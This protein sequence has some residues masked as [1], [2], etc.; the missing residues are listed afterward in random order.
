MV[1]WI[2]LDWIGYLRPDQFLDQLTMI[3]KWFPYV[4]NL[5]NILTSILM[6]CIKCSINFPRY[7]SLTYLNYWVISPPYHCWLG[8][9]RLRHGRRWWEVY[10][11]VVEFSNCTLF[12][13]SLTRLKLVLP[14]WNIELKYRKIA[15]FWIF[16]HQKKANSKLL[17]STYF[18]KTLSCLRTKNILKKTCNT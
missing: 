7:F 9:P 11:G 14:L 16:W 5:I 8:P 6:T 17:T 15:L 4:V 13:Y 18:W 2:G 1:G 12:T 3:I 10:V